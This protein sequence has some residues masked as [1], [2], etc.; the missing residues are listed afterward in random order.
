MNV[1]PY[2]TKVKNQFMGTANLNTAMTFLMDTAKIPLVNIGAED[3]QHHNLKIIMGLIWQL[4]IRF[5]LQGEDGKGGEKA[6]KSAMLSWIHDTLGAMGNDMRIDDFKRSFMDGKA[7][8]AILHSLDP[9]L[10][11][12]EQ[13][14]CDDA[15]T[16][17][18]LA[19]SLAEEHFGVARIL[20]VED[21]L[22]GGDERAV[23]TYVSQIFKAQRAMSEAKMKDLEALRA[24][25]AAEQA[26]KAELETSLGD[27]EARILAL[28]ARID[29][30][31]KALAESEDDFAAKAAQIADLRAQLGA[32][33]AQA[34]DADAGAAQ[35]LADLKAELDALDA[36][37]AAKAAKKKA[38]RRRK[39]L[40]YAAQRG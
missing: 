25:H 29:E 5:E 15:R 8:L 7:F 21:M 38:R 34:A 40:A 12:E 2:T 32:A 23:L 6:A 17:L 37:A 14:A 31:E 33:K 16:N 4:I 27:A 39:K 35:A 19:F 26:S 20:D 11:T 28:E 13:L 3:I 1:G 10:L 36:K 24:A 22:N 9:S 18:E 30:L